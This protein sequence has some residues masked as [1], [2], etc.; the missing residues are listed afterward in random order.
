MQVLAKGD[1]IGV[2]D[3]TRLIFGGAD[4]VSKL[5]VRRLARAGYLRT[6]TRPPEHDYR[7]VKSDIEEFMRRR[8]GGRA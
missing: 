8:N 3:A 1:I 2:S 5:A 4:F 7:L 6:L